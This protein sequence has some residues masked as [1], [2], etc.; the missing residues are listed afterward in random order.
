MHAAACGVI[1]VGSQ[2]GYGNI[3]CIDHGS[4][5]TTC[6]AHLS[7]FNTRAARRSTPAT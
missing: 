4:G 5:F 3:V 6:Y 2:S 7:G 1:R